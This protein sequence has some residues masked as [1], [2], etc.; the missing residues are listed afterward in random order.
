MHN[1]T[2]AAGIAAAS[3]FL[4]LSVV[5]PADAHPVPGQLSYAYTDGDD[6]P[7]AD[8]LRAP[9]SGVCI[10][11]PALGD[12]PAV[13]LHNDSPATVKLFGTRDCL[14]HPL[15]TVHPGDRSAVHTFSVWLELPR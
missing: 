15:A 11:L 1:R 9:E 3:S 14:G 5:G 2:T 13:H 6:R 4:L 10:D 12:A 8:V 7:A